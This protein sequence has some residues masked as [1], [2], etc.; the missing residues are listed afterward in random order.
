MDTDLLKNFCKVIESGTIA[1]A[2]THLHMTPGALSRSLKRLEGEIGFSLFKSSG[3]NIIPTPE[4]KLFYRESQE[5]LGRIELARQRIMRN[6]QPTRQLT[7][8]SFEVFTTHLLAKII[9][10]TLTDERIFLIEKTPGGIEE[11]ILSGKVN[12]GLT[13]VS[14][15][16]PELDHLKFGEMRFAIFGA[17]KFTGG[18]YSAMDLPFAIPATELDDQKM[19][20][21]M[22]DGWPVKKQRK[23]CFQFDQLETAIQLASRGSCVLCAPETVIRVH[24]ERVR[25]PFQLHELTLI[26]S[27]T[28]PRQSVYLI[29]K[30]NTDESPEIKRL[31]QSLRKLIRSL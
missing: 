16:H 6:T 11:S 22:L 3:R 15:P 31:I 27:V 5:I 10:E 2:S 23:V 8:A 19:N 17:K 21:T 28:L 29:K 24:N 14:S 4:A 9:S 12:F 13:Y 7:L 30:K 26:E 1:S 25:E 18:K 20:A